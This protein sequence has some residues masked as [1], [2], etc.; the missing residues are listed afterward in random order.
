[1]FDNDWILLKIITD[2]KWLLDKQ[3]FARGVVYI[4][5]KINMPLTQ[6]IR[7]T[8]KDQQLSRQGGGAPHGL[9]TSDVV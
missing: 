4:P 3:Q 1:M 8:P 6:R 7:P 5:F 2:V 9:E